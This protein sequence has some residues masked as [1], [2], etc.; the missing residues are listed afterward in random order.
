[1]PK[2]GEKITDQATLDRLAKCREKANLVRKQKAEERQ[3]IK[4]AQTLEHKEKVAYANEKNAQKVV[5]ESTKI[6]K[7]I[8]ELDTTNETELGPT[9]VSKT[10]SKA[11]IHKRKEPQKPQVVLVEEEYTD[12]SSSSSDEEPP[13]QVIHRRKSHKTSSREKQQPNVNDISP[14]DKAYRSLFPYM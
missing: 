1:M 3:N 2:K 13:I 6:L 9:R 12:E 8:E 14:F 5:P 11:L 4:L 10:R 7:N